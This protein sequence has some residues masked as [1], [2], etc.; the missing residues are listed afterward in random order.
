MKMN[1]RTYSDVVVVRRDGR[2]YTLYLFE[3]KNG[4]LYKKCI[5]SNCS[6]SILREFLKV[7]IDFFSFHNEDLLVQ[8]GTTLYH[9]EDYMRIQNKRAFYY[10]RKQIV[11]D[12]NKRI[13]LTL[14]EKKNFVL[15]KNL[16][17]FVLVASILTTQIGGSIGNKKVETKEMISLQTVVEMP[18]EVPV[19]TMGQ[20]E[21]YISEKADIEPEYVVSRSLTEEEEQFLSIVE[22]YSRIF[23]LDY[24]TVLASIRE[25]HDKIAYE[26]MTEEAGIIEVISEAYYNDDT[27]DKTPIVS[28]LTS[29]DREGLLLEFAKAYGISEEDTLATIL[30]IYR[31]ETG[32]GTSEACIQY[33]NYGGLMTSKNGN[34]VLRKFKTAEI[35]AIS[36][37]ATFFNI[38]EKS[39]KRE[40][41][42]PNRPMEENL[43]PIYCPE[44]SWVEKVR[45]IKL[46]VYED[47]NLEYHVVDEAPKILIRT[48]E[49]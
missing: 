15:K 30:A 46:E 39:K 37:I 42:D 13:L 35:G 10:F 49:N 8:S 21:I 5:Y 43:F 7:E 28:D 27:I 45:K 25:N 41:Y 11:E 44:E 3:E 4:E 14:D 22:K 12:P 38:L 36:Q 23:F 34:N 20:K 16:L 33:N 26:S 19:E 6:S 24:N 17:S 9:I 47:Y 2:D 18:A 29:Q 1:E 40:S 32:R 48:S 31:L